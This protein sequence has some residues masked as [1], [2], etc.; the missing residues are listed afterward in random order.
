LVNYIL[1][2][3]A[4]YRITHL[5]V[6]EDGPFDLA[7]RLRTAVNLRDPEHESWLARGLSC[8]LCLSFWLA[9]GPAF[10]LPG[11]FVFD[12]L[13]VAGLVMVLHKVLYD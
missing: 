1:A 4:V 7:T 13:G 11:Q 9:L 5:I 12:W 2:V 6:A 8:V 3:T 10:L